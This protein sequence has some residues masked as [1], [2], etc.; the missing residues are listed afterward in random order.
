MVRIIVLVLLHIL[1]DF[2]LQGTKLS[3]RKRF[4]L[5]ALMEHTSIY[6]LT[7]LILSPV[8]LSLTFIQGVVFSLLNG[9]L[10]FCIDY[11][12]GIMK[13]K[14]WQVD[15]DKYFTAIG[16]DQTLHIIILIV[17]YLMLFPNIIQAPTLFGA[18]DKILW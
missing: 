13:K 17:T 7:F 12:T 11:I 3:K 6:T 2:F 18:F 8:L 1:G 5:P 4:H 16:L 9:F 10:H 15:E 14:Y